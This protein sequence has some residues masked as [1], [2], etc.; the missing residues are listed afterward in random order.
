[1]FEPCTARVEEAAPSMAK[2]VIGMLDSR[3]SSGEHYI[4]LVH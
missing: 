2:R 3:S 4:R 1:M